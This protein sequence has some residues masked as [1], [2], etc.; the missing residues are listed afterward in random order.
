MINIDKC[1]KLLQVAVDLY[2]DD[3]RKQ[4]E[5]VKFNKVGL[6]EL[7]KTLKVTK[8]L[9]LKSANEMIRNTGVYEDEYETSDKIA[10]EFLKVLESL[11]N[12]EAND[13]RH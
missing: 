12:D 8:R 10:D 3:F 6:I 11:P 1:V 2:P 9:N 7:V 4:V 13:V 5:F